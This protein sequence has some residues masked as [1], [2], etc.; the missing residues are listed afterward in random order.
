MKKKG[1]QAGPPSHARFRGS[2]TRKV[3]SSSSSLRCCRNWAQVAH[4]HTQ[5]RDSL[6][7]SLYVC[8]SGGCER[9]AAPYFLVFFSIFFL[10]GLQGERYTHIIKN[11]IS[12]NLSLL[13]SFYSH[14]WWVFGYV[15]FGGTDR[16]AGPTSVSVFSLFSIKARQRKGVSGLSSLF[17][18]LSMPKSSFF[19]LFFGT[20]G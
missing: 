6:S 7:L 19:V 4:T 13:S 9:L 20:F 2:R 12:T 14:P 16:A 11:G 10:P 8:I 18:F 5:T 1:G 3:F 15:F 17:F